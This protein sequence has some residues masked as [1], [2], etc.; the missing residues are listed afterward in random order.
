MMTRRRGVFLNTV[1]LCHLNKELV[2]HVKDHWSN[3]DSTGGL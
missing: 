2:V 3:C 1:T